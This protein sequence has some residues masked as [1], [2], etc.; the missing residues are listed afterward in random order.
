[1][2]A[3]LTAPWEYYGIA[4]LQRKIP[5]DSCADNEIG[6]STLGQFPRFARGP[7]R[8]QTGNPKGAICRKPRLKGTS[9]SQ[10]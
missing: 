7:D 2:P 3:A 5:S 8:L 9:W 1:M 6:E 10:A 4:S